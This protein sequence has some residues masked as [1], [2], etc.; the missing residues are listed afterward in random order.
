MLE[1]G[2]SRRDVEEAFA[3]ALDDVEQ[4]IAEDKSFGGPPQGS[5]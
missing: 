5:A 1:D 2:M 3:R 4:R